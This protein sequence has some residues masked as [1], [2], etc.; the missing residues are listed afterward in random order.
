MKNLKE[1]IGN[2]EKIKDI[3]KSPSKLMFLGA[4]GFLT[5][6]ATINTINI[7]KDY[8]YISKAALDF[9]EKK[10][11]SENSYKIDMQL[12]KIYTV[13]NIAK[14]VLPPVVLIGTSIYTTIKNK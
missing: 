11:I 8:K 6:E 12:R 14:E 10:E 13:K 2:T 3:T 7:I 1:I 4:V 9:L 5:Y